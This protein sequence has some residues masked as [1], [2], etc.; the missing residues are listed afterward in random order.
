M[1]ATVLNHCTYYPTVDREAWE[2]AIGALKGAQERFWSGSI[3]T[4]ELEERISQ[5]GKQYFKERAV[6]ALKRRHMDENV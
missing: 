6:S 2:K 1:K 5:A 4:K 3:S